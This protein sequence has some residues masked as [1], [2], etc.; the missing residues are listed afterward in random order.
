VQHNNGYGGNYVDCYPLGTYN[1]NTATDAANSYSGQA[2][3]VSSGWVCGLS[4]DTVTAVCKTTG[5]G[6]NLT[7]TCWNYAGTGTYASYVGYS[8]QSSGTAGDTGCYCA[9][10]L[11]NAWN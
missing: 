3:T 10:N 6:S 8:Y 2:G 1:P 11:A 5:N 9:T 4:P 7:C